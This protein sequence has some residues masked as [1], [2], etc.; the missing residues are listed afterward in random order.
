[1]VTKSLNWFSTLSKRYDDLC[2]TLHSVGRPK[3]DKVMFTAQEQKFFIGQEAV[4]THP[5]MAKLS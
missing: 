1:M 3:H 4:S 2:D 5:V